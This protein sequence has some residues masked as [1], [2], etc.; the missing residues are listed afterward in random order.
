MFDYCES[1][2]EFSIIKN[3]CFLENFSEHSSWGERMLEGRMFLGILVEYLREL[4]IEE[5]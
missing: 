4:S 2:R 1:S 5:L 3:T